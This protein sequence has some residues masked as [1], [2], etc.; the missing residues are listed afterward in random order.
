M[1]FLWQFCFIIGSVASSTPKT[2]EAATKRHLLTANQLK[3]EIEELF[4]FVTERKNGLNKLQNG[5]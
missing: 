3:N 2:S 5:D 4:Y 1:R